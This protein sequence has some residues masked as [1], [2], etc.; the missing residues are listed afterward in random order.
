MI[1]TIKIND[2]IDSLRSRDERCLYVDNLFIRYQS[3]YIHTAERQLQQ[4]QNKI[5]KDDFKQIPILKDENYM[6]SL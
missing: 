1:F 6:Y 4:S 5:I 2:K 3:T